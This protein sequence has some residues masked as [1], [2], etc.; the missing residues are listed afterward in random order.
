MCMGIGNGNGTGMEF[1][2]IFFICVC[3]LVSC[4]WTFYCSIDIL[5][6]RVSVEVEE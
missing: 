5:Y 2:M 1:Y 4:S 6:E 3:K